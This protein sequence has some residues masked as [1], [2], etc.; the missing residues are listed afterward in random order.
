[1]IDWANADE[2]LKTYGL[3]NVKVQ[4]DGNTVPFEWLDGVGFRVEVRYAGVTAEDG[5]RS[6]RM[7]LVTVRSAVADA[8]G[9]RLTADVSIKGYEASSVQR[10]TFE[11]NGVSLTRFYVDCRRIRGLAIIIR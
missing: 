11:E 6:Y 3:Y 7:P 1:M 9:A 10:E 2:A 4:D 8:V 5:E